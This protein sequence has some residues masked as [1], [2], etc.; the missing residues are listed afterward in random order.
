MPTIADISKWQGKV[1][2]ATLKRVLDLLIIRVQ[3]GSSYEDPL[4]KWDEAHALNY[5]IPFGEYAYGKYV[6]VKDAIV[7]AKDFLNRIDKHAK[8]LALDCEG[9]TLQS[10]GSTHIAE[11][12]QAFIDTCR[13]AGFKT[14]FYCAHHMYGSYGLNHV[15]SDFTWIPRYG[16][17]PVYPCD[18][19]QYTQTGKLAGIAGNVDLNK[20]NGDKDLNWFLGV[21]P[22]PVPKKETKSMPQK[23]DYIG[24]WA[25][26]AIKF[27][28]EKNIFH[29]RSELIF[30]PNATI[31]R[32]EVAVVAENLYNVLLLEVKNIL[33]GR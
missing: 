13:D 10:C 12:S 11:A 21:K 27:V 5:G 25:E 20:L 22:K 31:T 23:P 18:L 15:K 26:D 14:G 24:N 19:W 2:F 1:D 16:A 7:E 8:F 6:S 32:A 28:L 17:K 30:D 4:H 3:Y 9:D 33:A 29:G